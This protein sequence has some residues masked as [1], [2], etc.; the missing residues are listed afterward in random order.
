MLSDDEVTRAAHAFA[1]QC[2]GE[3]DVLRPYCELADP[4]GT[5]FCMDHPEGYVLTGDGG[6]FVSR[7]DGSIV[8]LGSGDFTPFFH[9]GAAIERARGDPTTEDALRKELPGKVIRRAKARH[10]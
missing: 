8:A 10:S 3:V 5:Y 7:I 6:F 2:Y 9:E 4:R 1:M